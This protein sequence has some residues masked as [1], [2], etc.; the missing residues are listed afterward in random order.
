M[1]I[2]WN[3]V[4]PTRGPTVVAWISGAVVV[5]GGAAWGLFS[6]GL[7]EGADKAKNQLE[8]YKSA[9][10]ARLPELS[11][12]LL[13]ISNDLKTSL[14]LYERNKELEAKVS[15]YQPQLDEA[16]KARADRD[17]AISRMK[18][19]LEQSATELARLKGLSRTFSLLERR[20]EK[21]IAGYTVG[22]KETYGTNV[23]NY[24]LDVETNLG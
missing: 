9:T 14:K 2:D 23:G 16:S 21:L 8:F 17:A 18:K 7:S 19:D 3:S 6:F 11:A 15:F 10:A 22:F 4:L 20:G 1:P 24:V 13:D 5:L 12:N